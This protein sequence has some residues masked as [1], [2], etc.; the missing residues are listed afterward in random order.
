M[1]KIWSKL[2][3]FTCCARLFG[4]VYSV[5]IKRQDIHK[6]FR[7][8]LFQNQLKQGFNVQENWYSP[9]TLHHGNKN[10]DIKFSVHDAF[11]E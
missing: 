4:R 1:L 8:R 11:L 9:H 3:F 5:L 7:D 10:V 6:H 2:Y